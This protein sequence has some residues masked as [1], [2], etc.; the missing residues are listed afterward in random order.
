M[1]KY[2][3]KVYVFIFAIIFLVTTLSSGCTALY[4]GSRY[5]VCPSNNKSFFYERVGLRPSNQFLKNY[6]Q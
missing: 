4:V 5:S 3:Y 2:N 1:K 6:K